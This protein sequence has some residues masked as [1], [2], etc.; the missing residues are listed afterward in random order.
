M[1]IAKFQPAWLDFKSQQIGQPKIET[2]NIINSGKDALVLE[3]I[4]GSTLN[5]YC[6]FFKEKVINPGENTTFN[7]YFLAR[8][9]G[10]VESTLFINTNKGIIKYSV[11]LILSHSFSFVF[12][13]VASFL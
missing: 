8:D 10:L 4:S 9:V 2:V 7:V 5:F 1:P 12:L 6:T 3:S 13:F 11:R